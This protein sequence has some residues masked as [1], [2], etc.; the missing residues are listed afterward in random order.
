MLSSLLLERFTVFEHAAFSWSPSI[1]VLVGVNGTGKTHVMKILYAVQ[2]CARDAEALDKKLAAVF[3]PDKGNLRRLIRKHADSAMIAVRWDNEQEVRIT[4]NPLSV[5]GEWRSECSP[6]YIPA[7]EMLSFAPSFI[8][9]YDTYAL[10][11]EEV[12]YDILRLACL[13]PRKIVPLPDAE[14]VLDKIAQAIGGQMR[15][16]EGIFRFSRGAIDNEWSSI[17]LGLISEGHRKLALLGQLIANGSL[18]QGGCLFWDEP[19]A[20]LNPSLIGTVVNVLL[21]LAQRGVQIFTVTHDYAF[22][23]EL[24]F[25]RKQAEIRYFALEDEG[26]GVVVHPS[27]TY[28]DLVPNR[29]ADEYRRLYDQV[30]VRAL[31]G[32][33]EL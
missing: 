32:D 29:I 10:P 21:E 15:F 26:D 5:A 23:R 18:K 13:P 1:N 12:Y 28:R 11:I 20:N 33:Q 2:L 27:D 22:L 7:K 19:E 6:V 30:I 25:Q 31:G 14:P 9:F 16:E 24:D 4:L 17:E 3:R 8:A